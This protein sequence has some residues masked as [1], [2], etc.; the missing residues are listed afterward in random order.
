MEEERSHLEFQC[1]IGKQ[2]ERWRQKERLKRP[3]AQLLKR[4]KKEMRSEGLGRDLHFPHNRQAFQH[5]RIPSAFCQMKRKVWRQKTSSFSWIRS[6]SRGR[7]NDLLF[8]L[9]HH[10]KQSLRR[11]PRTFSSEQQL[12]GLQNQEAQRNPWERK[13]EEQ[14]NIHWERKKNKSGGR[15]SGQEEEGRSNDDVRRR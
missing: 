11:K 12:Q 2:K 6:S 14:H 5:R 1:T 13:E 3:W 7:Q 9:L 15:A 8:H 4:G 10:T